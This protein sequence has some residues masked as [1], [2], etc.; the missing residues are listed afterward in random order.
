MV[1]GPA[2]GTTRMAV[3]AP[4]AAKAARRAD[5]L[6]AAS[7]TASASDCKGGGTRNLRCPSPNPM[8]CMPLMP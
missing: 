8:R 6:A 7:R 3:V 5:P 1:T 4:T 2:K